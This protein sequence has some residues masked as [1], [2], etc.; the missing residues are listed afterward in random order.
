MT[1]LKWHIDRILKERRHQ[2]RGMWQIKLYRTNKHHIVTLRDLETESIP[3]QNAGSLNEGCFGT[4]H[5]TYSC[6]VDMPIKL[7]SSPVSHLKIEMTTSR[8]TPCS[9]APTLQTSSPDIPPDP[10]QQVYVRTHLGLQ[11]SAHHG[12]V[13]AE[14]LKHF[15]EY[16]S[17]QA[18]PILEN[19]V[20]T[21]YRMEQISWWMQG[22]LCTWR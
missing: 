12:P 11:S 4:A 7:T 22:K 2:C 14:Q 17:L 19:Q 13:P 15:C 20:S 18:P 6:H 10:P 9:K 16:L 3:S 8:F 1:E 21:V 5:C